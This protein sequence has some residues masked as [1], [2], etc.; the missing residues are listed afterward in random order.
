MKWDRIQTGANRSWF[1]PNAGEPADHQLTSPAFEVADTSLTLSFKH[2]WSFE[3]SDKDMKDFDGGVV[4]GQGSYLP[5]A[6]ARQRYFSAGRHGWEASA[7]A[8]LAALREPDGAT[9][10]DPKDRPED[11]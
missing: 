8:R 6:L 1:I 7:S 4:P 10:P 11:T 5:D 9:E 2:R 3:S